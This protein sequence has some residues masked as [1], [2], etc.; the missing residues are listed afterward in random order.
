M[1]EII[2]YLKHNTIKSLESRGIYA[3]WSTIDSSKVSLT[4]DQIES[5]STDNLASQCR[6]IVLLQLTGDRGNAGEYRI[7]GR[8]FY[9]FF[10]VGQTAAKEVDFDNCIVEEKLD[11][12][13][14][15]GTVLNCYDGTT[16]TIGDVVD[17]H[18]SPILIGMNDAGEL[19]KSH[20]TQWFNN[21]KKTNWLEIDVSCP[22]NKNVGSSGHT[23]SLRVT[24]NHEINLN[25]TFKTAGEALVGDVLISAE[26]GPDDV[27]LHLIRSSL[28]GDGS[29]S[30]N[31]KAGAKFEERHSTAQYAYL[32]WKRN[33]LGE[34]CQNLRKSVSGY[35]FPGFQLSGY[36][37]SSLK[38]FREEWYPSGKK[39][40]PSDLDWMDDFS[41]AVWYM[42][43]GSLSHNKTQYQQDRASFATNG[44]TKPE[45]D[46]LAD[47][48]R[49]MYGVSCTVHNAKGWA[50]R[51]NS[52]QTGSI[53]SMWAAIAPYIHNS[54]SYKVPAK[55]QYL[56][57]TKIS[58]HRGITKLRQREATILAIRD[59]KPKSKQFRGNCKG[60]DI[61]TTTHNY[62]AKN[63]LVHNSLMIVYNHQNRWNIATKSVPDADITNSD[64]LTF[65]EKFWRAASLPQNSGV[66]MALLNAEGSVYLD[67]G[68]AIYPTLCFELTAPDNQIVVA[69]D[70]E[71]LTLLA[72]FD[73]ETGAEITPGDKICQEFGINRPKTY[74]LNTLDD[75]INYCNS[76]PGISF[77]GV[78]A[79]DRVTR[80]RVKIKNLQYLALAKVLTKAGSNTGL[81]TLILGGTVDDV[82]PYLPK[83]T[84]DKV[85]KMETA[86]R[87]WISEMDGMV[88]R[89][90]NEVDQASPN[91]R[92]DAAMII[93]GEST[94]I[95]WTGILLS[96]WTGHRS[97]FVAFL[98]EEK[99][100]SELEKIT[101]TVLARI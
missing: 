52:G 18:L 49:S 46:R 32:E 86:L 99:R 85:E 62:F 95:S 17:G 23:N 89:L 11:G 2:E 24:T 67:N 98:E 57:A 74:P 4:Y 39:I 70:E 48:L 80:N 92:K 16:V 41:V 51:V 14:H 56:V 3:R 84:L 44:F 63:V 26:V 65:A 50:I 96:I 69:Y 29:I 33:V 6:G 12:C 40:L 94:M 88:D 75:I 60:Y 1:N 81:M 72:V 55:F 59:L 90:R 35:G 25:G 27:S 100:P 78:V 87:A 9:R 73:T 71:V 66:A 36:T 91:P 54:L 31:G 61:E 5:A 43:D 15:R 83:P 13:L 42:D 7:L 93:K 101:E 58:D 37:Y 22:I 53:D 45:V 82:K 76:Q 34:S 79:V 10:N 8:P 19:V 97:G 64:G 28:L 30:M 47:K 20:V 77:E 68:R 38:R 21:G